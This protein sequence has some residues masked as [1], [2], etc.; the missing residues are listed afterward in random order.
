MPRALTVF[1]YCW[2][3]E[4]NGGQGG[5]CP[6][7]KSGAAAPGQPAGGL[8]DAELRD[9]PVAVSGTVTVGNF[10]AENAELK[11]PKAAE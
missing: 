11:K 1:A 9:S 2:D 8:T 3:P 5:W 7:L 6:T 4:A 10:P